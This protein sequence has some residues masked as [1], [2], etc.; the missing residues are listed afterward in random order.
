MMKSYLSV[1][2]ILLF[3][4]ASVGPFQVV[5]AL[6]ADKDEIIGG[7]NIVRSG[8]KQGDDVSG[9]MRFKANGTFA[10][11]VL[12]LNTYDGKYKFMPSKVIEL[13]FPGVIYGST[14]KQLK[15]KIDGDVLTLKGSNSI[16][17]EFKRFDC[18]R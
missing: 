7:W 5:A 12:P 3:T 15:Y 2:S 9:Y 10:S 11:S 16:D 18:G 14:K 13:E 8:N 1:F 6:A 17:M 4:L